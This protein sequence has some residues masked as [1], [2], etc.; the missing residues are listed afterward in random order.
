[1]EHY[2]IYTRFIYY[3][4][5]S[6]EN[7]QTLGINLYHIKL[8]FIHNFNKNPTVF[9][10]QTIP[11]AVPMSQQPSLTLSDRAHSTALHCVP[12]FVYFIPFLRAK[13]SENMRDMYRMQMLFT[14][15]RFLCN[16]AR[17]I[18]GY[19]PLTFI[20]QLRW[21]GYSIQKPVMYV[22]KHKIWLN[23]VIFKL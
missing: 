13:C 22:K 1:M 19:N 10:K 3:D 14:S 7:N 11:G 23:L 9:V 21:T 8:I 12:V 5:K 2:P 6:G 4:I 15:V 18:N 17:C 20:L 16:R